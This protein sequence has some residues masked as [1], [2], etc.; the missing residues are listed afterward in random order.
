MWI[1]DGCIVFTWFPSR[2][3][4]FH[5]PAGEDSTWMDVLGPMIGNVGW[6]I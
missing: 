5:L 4:F 6:M 1:L 2:P 3:F